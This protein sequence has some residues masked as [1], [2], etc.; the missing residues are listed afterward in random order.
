MHSRRYFVTA[1]EAG[2]KRASH[3]IRAYKALYIVEESVHGKPPEE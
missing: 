1:L 2:D 3:V